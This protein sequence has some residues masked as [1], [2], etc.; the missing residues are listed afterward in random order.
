MS[1]VWSR[2]T[3]A[4]LLT[5]YGPLAADVAMRLLAG[6]G[7]QRIIYQPQTGALLE[8]GTTVHDPPAALREHSWPATAAA[9]PRSMKASL[10]PLTVRSAT[11]AVDG[12]AMLPD[13]RLPD[14]PTP[15]D[16]PDLR[17]GPTA[18]PTAKPRPGERIGR[19]PPPAPGKSPDD[20]PS[21]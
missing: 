7:W 20:P 13:S 21:F 10:A 11:R 2:T 16:I 19:D 12:P 3:E 5:G 8:A 6:A 4:P 18:G 1:V 17:P 14:T 9:P 15:N